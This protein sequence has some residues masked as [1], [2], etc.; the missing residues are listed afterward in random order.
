MLGLVLSEERQCT[1]TRR[2]DKEGYEKVK[3]GGC[4]VRQGLPAV[5]RHGRFSKDHD[6]AI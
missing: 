2:Q 6:P 5:V 1:R 4:Q 3:E